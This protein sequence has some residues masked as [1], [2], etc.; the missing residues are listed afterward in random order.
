[1]SRKAKVVSDV[2]S[3]APTLTSE[4]VEILETEKEVV[5]EINN[6]NNLLQKEP[7]ACSVLGVLTTNPC[8]GCKYKNISS[9][10]LS[11]VENKK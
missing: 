1:M 3:E 9:A 7:D 4:I 5:T 10:C 11:C 2:V 8:S 6:I